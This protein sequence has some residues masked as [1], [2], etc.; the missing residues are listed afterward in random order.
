[1]LKILAPVAGFAAGCFSG[2]LAY[3]AWSFWALLAPM[4]VLCALVCLAPE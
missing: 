3:L 1:M 2:G 4:A